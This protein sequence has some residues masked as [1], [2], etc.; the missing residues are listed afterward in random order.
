[1]KNQKLHEE[2][3][4]AVLD[5]RKVEAKLISLLQKADQTR[6]YLE[7]GETSLFQYCVRVLD[8]S[9]DRAYALITVARK[10][11]EI[12][13]LQN[14]IVTNALSVSKAVRITSVLKKENPE[15][16][17]WIEKAV[18][19]PKAQLEKAVATSGEVSRQKQSKA[20]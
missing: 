19:L 7:F 13:E 4:L 2:I 14:A 11:R 3:L 20:K 16:L 6:L 15:N 10:A 17:N 9:D 18:S 5:Y 1:M 8:L 12:P